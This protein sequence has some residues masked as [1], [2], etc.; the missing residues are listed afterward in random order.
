MSTSPEKQIDEAL[1]V[2]ARYQ[3][4]LAQR[5]A[6]E[7]VD[8]KDDFATPFLGSAEMLIDK[9]YRQLG[10]MCTIISTLQEYSPTTLQEYS[11][12]FQAMK[13]EA[14]DRTEGSLVLRE[15][16]FRCFACGQIISNNPGSCP[17]CGWTWKKDSV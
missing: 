10:S 15:D 8:A 12:R 6:E 11:P 14:M 9:Y 3:R 4:K 1:Q 5:M 17:Y 16:Q 13:R 2:L 7:I